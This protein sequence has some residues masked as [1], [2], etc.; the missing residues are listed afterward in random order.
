MNTTII[1]LTALLPESGTRD[2]ESLIETIN[3]ADLNPYELVT[4]CRDTFNNNI[5]FND[6]MYTT[7]LAVYNRFNK[8]LYEAH[9]VKL[10]E[11]IIYPNYSASSIE[12]TVDVDFSD[13]TPANLQ[14]AYSSW[15]KDKQNT[16]VS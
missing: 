11:C 3:S 12:S 14:L 16:Q 2:I 6:L 9:N 1:L 7:L 13:I 10:P 4:D 5:T 8:A 15:V